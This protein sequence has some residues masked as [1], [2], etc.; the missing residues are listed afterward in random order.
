MKR[1]LLLVCLVF[2]INQVNA[3]NVDN[4]SAE[5]A[6]EKLKAGNENYV[7]QKLK[8]PHLT[9]DRRLEMKTGQHP[10]AT[11][12]SCSDSRVPAEIIFDQG[13]GDI[14]VIRNAG[15]VIDD[16]V[17]A[18][19]EY[20]VYHLGTKLVV[21]MGHQNCGAVA[22]SMASNKETQ[23]IE[24]SIK[25][26]IKHSVKK[27]EKEHKLTADNVTV[28]NLNHDIDLIRQKDAKL[29][30]YMEEHN[31]KVIKAYYSIDTGKVTFLD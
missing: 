3:S 30:K 17:L 9:T 25:S 10:F 13:L 12:L 6:L 16:A 11:V 15:N 24:S 21:I 28:E 4:L 29:A 5:Q 1:L 31:V 20:A 18:S 23:Y 8:H 2:L 14:F 7:E 19:M 27:C 26:P 22:A